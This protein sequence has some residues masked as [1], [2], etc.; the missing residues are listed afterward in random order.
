[1]SNPISFFGNLSYKY[2]FQGS[3]PNFIID[4][5]LLDFSSKLLFHSYLQIFLFEMYLTK[6]IFKMSI[7]EF[8]SNLVVRALYDNKE[9][10]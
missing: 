1:M 10:D 4:I 9:S 7:S 8:S 3:L 5:S 6:V 2:V